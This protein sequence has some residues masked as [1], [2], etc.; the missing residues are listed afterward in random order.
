MN[1]I[2]GIV[3][4]V[5]TTPEGTRS[6]LRMA[7]PLARGANARL[8]VLVPQ[9]V[10]YVVDGDRPLESADVAVRRLRDMVEALDAEAAIRVCLCRRFEDVSRLLPS[11]AT[12]VVGGEAARWLPSEVQRLVRCISKLGHDVMFVAATLLVMLALAAPSAHAQGAPALPSSPWQYGGFVDAA[13]LFDVN[14]PAN[15]LFRNRGTTATVDRLDLDMAAA[16]VRKAADPSS[17]L[18]FEATVQAGKDSELFG[19]SS[20][21]PNLAG[22]DVLRHLGPTDISYLAP[23]GRGLLIQGGIFSSLIG[24]DGLYAKDNLSYTRPWGADYTPFL[25][26]GVNAAYPVTP[27]VTI[28][29]FVVNGYFHLA[30]AND[31]PSVGGQA[32]WK[33]SETITAKEAVLYGSHQRDTAIES[34]RIFSDAIVERR[35]A[36]TTAAIEW[37]Y[38]SERLP[39]GRGRALWMAAQAPVHWTIRGPWSATVR[40]EFAR[41]RDGRWIGVP[42]TVVALTGTLEYRRPVGPAT[43][44][45]R[46]EYRL[47]HA[48]GSGGGFFEGPDNHLTPSQPLFVAAAILTF[49]GTT[50]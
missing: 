22:A 50:R 40:G 39:G 42:E 9:V 8:L 3:H 48:T 28:T 6:A 11:G 25:M 35:T 34:W 32:A 38:G 27:A 26:M 2:Q 18:G 37:Q 45:V 29:G 21:A 15:D 17:R 44:I 1:T 19:F 10:P 16:Y 24:Y 20:V 41:D 13:T 47:D 49:D 30:H 5:A 7:V 33:L 31:A 23:I 14:A 43:A 4:V 12:V 36:R 46:G